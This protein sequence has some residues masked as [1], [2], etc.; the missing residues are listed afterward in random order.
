MSDFLIIKDFITFICIQNVEYGDSD[1][2]QTK[3]IIYTTVISQIEQT[4]EILVLGN[5]SLS[6]M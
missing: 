4:R 1:N 3:K 6:K 2:V 5:L